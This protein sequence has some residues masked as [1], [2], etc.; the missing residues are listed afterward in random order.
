[1]K[2]EDVKEQIFQ[3]IE[4]KLS[5]QSFND[6][7]IDVVAQEL[8]ISKR[9]IYELFES[10]E[11]ILKNVVQ[12]H[13]KY[14]VKVF[15]QIVSDI[16]NKKITF[17]VGVE[18]LMKLH[19]KNKMFTFSDF[20][21]IAYKFPDICNKISQEQFEFS[22]VLLDLAIE[23]NIVR[24]NLNKKLFHLIMQSLTSM[25]FNPKIINE[26]ELDFTKLIEIKEMMFYGIL[27]DEA[28]KTKK[29]SL[30]KVKQ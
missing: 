19:I 13:H 6:I 23:H 30:D 2:K 10:K 1:M 8:R 11:E 20:S 3:K 24:A 9:T 16:K 18:E 28:R 15:E 25:I 27:T 4:E 7:R 22:N 14:T 17:Y 12:R 5:K 29:D 26:Y 21:D